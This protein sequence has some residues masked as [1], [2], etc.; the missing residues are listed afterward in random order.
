MF[1]L[2]HNDNI[3]SFQ[4]PRRA[5]ERYLLGHVAQAKCPQVSNPHVYNIKFILITDF[6]SKRRNKIRTDLKENVLLTFKKMSAKRRRYKPF[7]IK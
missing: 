6:H 2:Y 4:F 3:Y 5:F 7:M 1:F